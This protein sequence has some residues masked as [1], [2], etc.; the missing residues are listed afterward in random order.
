MVRMPEASPAWC[1]GRAL[2]AAREEAVMTMPI[3]RPRMTNMGNKPVR[4]PLEAV[5]V[6]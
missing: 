6:A 5:S 2:M 3:P 4:Y 1:S